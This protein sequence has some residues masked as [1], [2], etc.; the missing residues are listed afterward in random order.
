MKKLFNIFI[1]IFA[2]IGLFLTAGYFAVKFGLTNTKGILDEQTKGFLEGRS[3][4]AIETTNLPWNKGEEWQI[5]K[6]AIIKD[7]AVLKRVE[8]ETGINARTIVSTLIVEQL[9][10]FYSER[11]TFK[12]VFAPLKILGT[13]S[14]FS[15]GVAGIKPDTAKQIEQNLKNPNSPY[16]LGVEF[17][18]YLNFKTEDTD[19]ERFARMT[20]YEDRYFSYLYSALYLKEIKVGWKKSGFPIDTNI[21]VLATLFNIGFENS[22]PKSN[23][24]IGGAEIEINGKIYSFGG[25]AKEFYDSNELIE[26][27]P[28]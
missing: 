9:R 10:L 28:R 5:F 18:N 4:G 26:Y 7:L 15:W 19:K 12:E 13:Q 22:K 21:G 25:L 8:G 17:E 27:F 16:Y 6:N 1:Y 20:D 23:P 3:L 14:Q 24:E 11:Q 2:T